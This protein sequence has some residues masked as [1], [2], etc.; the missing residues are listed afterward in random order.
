MPSSGSNPAVLQLLNRNERDRKQRDRMNELE[1]LRRSFQPDRITTLFV[2]ESAP[3]SGKF[4]YLQNTGLYRA[5]KLVFNWKGDFLSE[6]KTR[7]F[8][9]DD[10][11]LIPVNGMERK[12]RRKQCEESV[13]SLAIRLKGYRPAAIVIIGRGVDKWIRRATNDAGLDIPIRCTTYPGRFQKL[14]ERF[15]DEM[16]SIIPQLFE[17]RH[18]KGSYQ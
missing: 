17:T 12:E 18:G 7:G 13:A 3:R 6:F 5:M 9:F 10:L 15:K 2:G 1:E 11:S 8:Y 16:A 14:R 4:F